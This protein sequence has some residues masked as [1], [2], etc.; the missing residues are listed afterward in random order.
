MSVAVALATFG[1]C[2]GNGSPA[3]FQSSAAQL[4]LLSIVKIT[5]QL[6]LVFGN[7]AVVHWQDH[8]STV[9]LWQERCCPLAR[10]LINCWSLARTLLSIVKITHQLLLVFGKNAV[11][12]WQD[13]SSTVDLWQERCCPLSRSLISYCCSLARTL[14]SIGKNYH[15]LLIFDKNAVVHWQEHSPSYCWSLS[16]TRIET[17]L[18][19]P[20]TTVIV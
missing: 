1:A 15:Q 20:A 4:W 7:N 12:H 3:T 19:I 2:S 5:H 17:L 18:L 6:L 10:S 8:S 14:L 16:K 11:V 9:G 13:H